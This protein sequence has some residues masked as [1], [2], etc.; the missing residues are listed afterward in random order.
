MGEGRCP[1]T[2]GWFRVTH[3]SLST[4]YAP[5]TVLGAW[6]HRVNK[7]AKVFSHL[8]LSCLRMLKLTT[9]YAANH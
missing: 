5:G 9:A 4:Y 1:G 2:D 3:H 6:R 8:V 7:I